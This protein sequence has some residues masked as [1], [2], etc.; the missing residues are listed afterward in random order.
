MEEDKPVEDSKIDESKKNLVFTI[1]TSVVVLVLALI[2]FPFFY[3][4]LVPE[5]YLG[6]YLS[7]NKGSKIDVGQ[8]EQ[9]IIAQ[10]NIVPIPKSLVPKSYYIIF[11][12][13]LIEV[14]AINETN[15]SEIFPLF[16]EIN[17]LAALNDFAS[18]QI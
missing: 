16:E 8:V 9:D 15:Y 4:L 17:K 3:A 11:N 10:K 6:R 2:V 1:R 18:L 7:R 14:F 12:L 5:S 13:T